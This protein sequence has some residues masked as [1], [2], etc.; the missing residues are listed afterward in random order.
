MKVWTQ[1]IHG[2][3]G[4]VLDSS[5]DYL[6][7]T[8]FSQLLQ[9]TSSASFSEFYYKV[10]SD[11]TQALQK[12]VVD[13]ITTGETS[14]FRDTSPFDVLQHKLL[15]ELIDRKSKTTPPGKRIPI[16]IWCAASSTGQ[17]IY[18]IGMVIRDLLGMSDKYDPTI[19]GTDISDQAIA[20]ASRGYYN[21]IEMDRGMDPAK[22]NK[23]FRLQEDKW[24][25]A[26]EVRALATFKQFN[27]LGSFAT[28]GKFDIVFC[29]NVAIYFSEADRKR[30]FDN[31]G[32]VMEPDGALVI[33]STESLSGIC[34]QYESKRYLRAVYYQKK[35]T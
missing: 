31:I 34:P 2:V 28:L 9:S 35:L 4:I 30:V 33:G 14:F 20:Y 32:S 12:K 22:L 16:R 7:E 27:L 1:Y 3:T 25:V 6:L 10:K 8:R 19:L 21:K 29:R 24:K 13:A 11:T 18:S 23:Y 5:K 17:E 26:D 15:P